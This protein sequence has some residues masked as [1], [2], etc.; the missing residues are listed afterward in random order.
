MRQWD[1]NPSLLYAFDERRLHGFSSLH[2]F[3]LI[4]QRY[5]FVSLS[6]P[7][8]ISVFSQRW[9]PARYSDSPGEEEHTFDLTGLWERNWDG[10]RLAIFWL[11]FWCVRWL[12]LFSAAKLAWSLSCHLRVF[13]AIC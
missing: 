4:W 13:F 2:L 3:I 5:L 10:I 9:P 11:F 7:L 6:H 12:H 8:F 1:I